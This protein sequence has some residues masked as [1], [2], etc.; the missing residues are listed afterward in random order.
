V[1]TI[2]AVPKFK[3]KVESLHGIIHVQFTECGRLFLVVLMH[4]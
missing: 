4:Q 2:K 3:L 1:K